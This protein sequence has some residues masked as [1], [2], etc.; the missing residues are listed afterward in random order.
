MDKVSSGEAVLKADHMAMS[1]EMKHF[2]QEGAER[3]ETREVKKLV[4]VGKQKL[5]RFRRAT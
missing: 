2:F 5:T 4:C 1:S 3:F